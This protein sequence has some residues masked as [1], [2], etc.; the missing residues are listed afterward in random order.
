MTNHSGGGT[1]RTDIRKFRKGDL[2]D[3]LTRAGRLYVSSDTELVEAVFCAA[4]E[5]ELSAAQSALA[6]TQQTL[7]STEE[8]AEKVNAALAELDKQV[9]KLTEELMVAE[10]ALAEKEGEVMVPVAEA[11]IRRDGAIWEISALKSCGE[12]LGLHLVTVYAK[13]PAPPASPT[14]REGKAT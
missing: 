4:L 5:L 9:G 8:L 10:S 14:G 3:P 2:Y 11:W 7:K 12:Q 1:P 13:L 6:K